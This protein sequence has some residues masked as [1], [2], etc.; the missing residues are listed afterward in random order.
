VKWFGKDW[1]APVCK[2]ER[3]AETPVGESC[4][5]CQKPIE[6]ADQGIMIAPFY[7]W[8]LDCFVRNV[9]GSEQS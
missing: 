1:G 2:E 8:H 5:V 9:T 4:V 6:P 7:V 3:H